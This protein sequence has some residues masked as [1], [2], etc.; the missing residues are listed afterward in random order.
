M[1]VGFFAHKNG[2]MAGIF[3][4]FGFECSAVREAV[5]AAMLRRSLRVPGSLL[6]VEV[7]LSIALLTANPASAQDA[8]Q[9]P[10]LQPLSPKVSA[11]FEQM[12]ADIAMEKEDIQS[13]E[14]R[15]SESE[16]VAADIFRARLDRTN[17]EMFQ[18]TLMLAREVAAQRANGADVSLYEDQ[19]LSDLTALPDEVLAA[20]ERLRAHVE[21]PSSDLSPEEFVYADQRLFK[22]IRE[23]DANFAVLIDYFQIVD[24]FGLDPAA[25]KESLE[26]MLADAAANRSLF[27]ELAINDVTFLRSAVATLPDNA[28]LAEW[29]S[30]AETRVQMTARSMQSVVGLMDA[31]GLETRQYRKQVLMVTGEITTDVLDVGIVANLLADW[32]DAFVKLVAEDGVRLLFRLL[33]VVL[34]VFAFSQLAKVAQKLVNRALNSARVRISHLLKEMV[35]SAVR[36][37]I[38]ILGVLF[39]ISQ[40]GISLG[41]LLAGLGIAGFIIGFA[42]QDSL[43]NFASGMLILLYRPFDVGDVVEAHGIKGRV[44]HMSLVNTIFMTLDNQKLIVPNNLIWSSVITN[45]TAQRTRRIDLIFGISYEDDVEK[46]ERVLQDIIDNHEA[47]LDVPEPIVKVHEL[48]DSSVNFTVR[49]WVKTDDYWDTYWDLNKAVKLRFD[50]EGISIPYPQRDVHVIEK[51]PA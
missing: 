48:G 45:V 25:H 31:L 40:L 6:F 12:R 11:Q 51:E 15:L 17:T 7:C 42:L 16:A 39:A 1:L 2:A 46:A 8:G 23:L 49:P 30:A 24:Q 4:H 27:L 14:E 47:V 29:L 41:P 35:V 5:F 28:K 33:L 3:L 21:F 26:A 20:I 36:N 38:V 9:E 19:L 32:S 13:L 18:N 10:D 44:S 34:I 43:A 50:Q 22:F 37:L